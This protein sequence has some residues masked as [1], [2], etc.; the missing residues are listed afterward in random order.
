MAEEV[1]AA[2]CETSKEEVTFE[3]GK[4]AGKS[5]RKIPLSYLR[6]ASQQPT[7]KN[8]LHEAVIAE[9]ERKESMRITRAPRKPMRICRNFIKIDRTICSLRE[10]RSIRE[11]HHP[12]ATEEG[13]ELTH[14]MTVRPG[15]LG[16]EERAN[17]NIWLVREEAEI[18]EELLFAAKSGVE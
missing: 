9:I 18:L 7:L 10:I 8:Q 3:Y 2:P 17:R 12:L 4:Y 14:V 13:V 16:D 5:L 1:Q 11:L 6:W 15:A